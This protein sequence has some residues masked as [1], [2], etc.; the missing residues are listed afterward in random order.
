MRQRSSFR[1]ENEFFQKVFV[2][3]FYGINRIFF[4]GLN[5]NQQ[6][7]GA[8]KSNQFVH[9]EI[10]LSL[11]GRALAHPIR[12]RIINFLISHGP[13]RNTDFARSLNLSRPSVKAHIDMLKDAGLVEIEYFLHY[14]HIHLRKDNLNDLIKFIE[15][16]QGLRGI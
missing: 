12:I 1:C 9:E 8:H 4:C 7:R 15:A 2:R 11:L 13:F 10:H 3:H 16:C 6:I 5:R 14:Y